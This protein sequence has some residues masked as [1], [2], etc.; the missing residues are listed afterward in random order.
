MSISSAINPLLTLDYIRNEPENKYF[1]RKDAR[2]KPTDLAQDISGF[3]NAEGA[4][5]VIGVNDKTRELEGINSAGESHINELIN[6]ANSCCRPMPAV[7][8]EFLDI[9]NSK[10]KPDR[11]LLLHIAPSHLKAHLYE[12]SGR[13]HRQQ[14]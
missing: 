11:L 7:R 12:S 14:G 3:A 4:T 13:F 10:G 8:E 2:I 9:I 5:I 6:A 1:D